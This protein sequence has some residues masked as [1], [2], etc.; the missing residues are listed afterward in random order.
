MSEL[1]QVF[2]VVDTSAEAVKLKGTRVD[3]RQALNPAIQKGKAHLWPKE[4]SEVFVDKALD[5]AIEKRMPIMLNEN[6]WTMDGKQ[7]K[8]SLRM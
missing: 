8:H 6:C 4:C 2:V 7:L 1:A 5:E 3:K